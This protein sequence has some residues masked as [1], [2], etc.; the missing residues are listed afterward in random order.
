MSFERLPNEVKELTVEEMGLAARASDFG[1]FVKCHNGLHVFYV[2]LEDH[3][4]KIFTN[5]G[6]LRKFLGMEH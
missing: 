5:I 6:R 3:G 2:L 4:S 1:E